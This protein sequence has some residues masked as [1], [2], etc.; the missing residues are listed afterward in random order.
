MTDGV[1]LATPRGRALL[2]ATALGS[3][4]AFLDSTVVNVALPTIG[5]E[6]DATLAAL[7]WTVNAYTLTLAALI[8]LGG[9]LGDRLGRRRVYLVGVVWFTAAS[10]L[11][12][13]APT[14]EVL[15]AARALQ[16][17]GGALLTPGALAILQT[18]MHPDDRPRAIGAWAGLTGVSGVLGP[19]LGGWL[20]EYDWRWVFA[21]N[22]PLAVVTVWLV[23][24]S[25]PESR[26]EQAS[27]KFDVAGAALGAIALGASTYA[28]ISWPEDGASAL[29]VGMAVL[30]VAAAAG[31]LYRERTATHPMVPLTLFSDRTFSGINLMTFA[32]YAGL[33]GVM[34]FIVIQL[35][36][37]L[38]WS[39]LE[40]G[41]ATI[42]TTILMLVFSGRSAD[43]A[44]R[45]GVRPP[46][47]VG[48]LAGAAGVVLLV[49]VDAGDSYVTDVLP[50]V[51]LLGIG[52]T[53]LVPTLTAT[54]MAS[55]PQHL[56][57]VAS[58]V[59]NGVARAA[60]LLAVA[61][62]P[63]IAGLS[64]AAYEDPELLTDAYR[65][66]M[67]VCAALLAV[68]AVAAMALRPR[69]LT[70]PPSTALPEPEPTPA[71]CS[72][73]GLPPSHGG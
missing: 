6:L 40:A 11:C 42:P 39:P 13:L 34:F 23:V 9:S 50:G 43:L 44:K 18:A 66:A 16:G 36:V 46:L 25:A 73:P 19:L 61:A 5:R 1:R 2:A 4:M 33:S 55:A 49:T 38:G 41:I 56:A 62:L 22:V 27:G 28:L 64:G 63:A 30:S 15:I 70:E 51:T 60:G 10:V 37:T 12:A 20:L 24:V 54:V 14:V 53:T 17:I 45:F 31:F 26:D 71:P 59:N 29:N 57:G 69:A 65:I 8:L 3:G 32:V 72:A 35:Q 48:S 68:G 67:G 52:L 47:V 58:G 21:I 7:Q